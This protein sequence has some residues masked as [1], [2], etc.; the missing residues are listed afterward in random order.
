MLTPHPLFKV[1][2]V[3]C[4]ISLLL[5]ACGNR[6]KAAVGLNRPESVVFDSTSQR[7]LVSNVEGK[8]IVARE[9]NGTYSVF[10]SGLTAPKGMTT[11]NNMLYVA[12]VT[13]IKAFSIANAK[14]QFTIQ[15]YS[16]VG[17]NDLAYDGKNYLYCSDRD[18]SRLYRINLSDKSVDSMSSNQLQR[19]NGLIYDNAANR[20]I[21]VS[22]RDNCPIQAVNWETK[23]VTDL[24]QTPY[25]QLDGLTRDRI[26]NFYFT[27]WTSKSV[28]Y[29]DKD[30]KGPFTQIK[31]NLDGPADLMYNSSRNELAVPVMMQNRLEIIG[32]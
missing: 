7:Y 15:V 9:A 11:V 14:P 8:N 6:S 10:A 18:N 3:V 16:S 26:G 23:T 13:N 12:D 5:V 28:I 25:S 20:L 24:M 31:N 21:V 19:P 32:L 22:S 17:L 29:V 2:L 1:F 4:I 30:L 27:S